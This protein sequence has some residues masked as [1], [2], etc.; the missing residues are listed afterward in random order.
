M[1][2]GIERDLELL[3]E[4]SQRP[5]ASRLDIARR[6]AVV[7]C[8]FVRDLDNLERL[9]T[10]RDAEALEQYVRDHADEAEGERTST[11][12]VLAEVLIHEYLFDD[13]T[14]IKR[15]EQHMAFASEAEG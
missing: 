15:R 12:R 5:E 11:G 3:R 1:H 10:G 7:V 8:W 9:I 4:Y 2:R 13:Y 14:R 6:V